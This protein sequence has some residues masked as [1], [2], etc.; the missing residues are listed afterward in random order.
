MFYTRIP[1]G[2]KYLTL[3]RHNEGSFTSI[4]KRKYQELLGGVYF[5]LDRL[6][7]GA[8]WSLH[9]VYWGRWKW[10]NSGAHPMTR[11]T[12]QAFFPTGSTHVHTA[13]KSKQRDSLFVTEEKSSINSPDLS[14]NYAALIL[15]TFFSDLCAS[16]TTMKDISTRRLHSLIHPQN[17]HFTNNCLDFFPPS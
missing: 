13:I 15:F 9:L 7:S 12:L 3:N 5:G 1:L 10:W 8:F 4:N 17:K 11:L 16:K 14:F 6:N 2:S